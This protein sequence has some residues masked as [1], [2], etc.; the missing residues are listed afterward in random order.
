MRHRSLY[1]F[2]VFWAV[3]TL[4]LWVVGNLLSGIAFRDTTAL[5]LS[6]LVLGILNTIVRPILLV[7]TLPITVL[8]LGLFLL[9]VNALVLMLVAWLVPGFEVRS[10]GVGLI[11]A[12]LVSVVS[13]IINVMVGAR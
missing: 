2:I 10:F 1:E 12:V 9:V 11:A 4:S 13:Y 6:G 3:N 8:T 7:L 5:L